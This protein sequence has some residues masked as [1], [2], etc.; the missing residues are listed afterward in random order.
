MVLLDQNRDEYF[1]NMQ[2]RTNPTLIVVLVAMCFQ[3]M[4]WPTERN[5][6]DLVLEISGIRNKKGEILIAMFNQPQGFPE[7]ES[8]FFRVDTIR[9]LSG[10]TVR[11]VFRDL[12]FGEY[13][14]TMMHDEDVDGGMDYNWFG[15]PK[16]GYGFSTNYKPIF[17]APKFEET[18]FQFTQDGQVIK[19]EMIY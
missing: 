12:E 15:I 10:T 19:V 14:I 13:A 2:L 4:Y 8:R 1:C 5:N 16:E 6:A 18:S 17:R 7:D 3:S 9:G 11:T